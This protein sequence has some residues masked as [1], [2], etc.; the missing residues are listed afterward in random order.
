ML[1]SGIQMPK[2]VVYLST[3]A[4]LCSECVCVVFTFWEWTCPSFPLE[5]LGTFSSFQV[6]HV[7]KEE[8]WKMKVFCLNCVK[9]LTQLC[10][11]MYNTGFKSVLFV[12][13]WTEETFSHL[14][15]IKGKQLQNTKKLKA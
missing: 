11:C 12:L 5:K 2:V 9:I 14:N 7:F 4:L 15:L 3:T 8:L 13:T 6:T 10:L 1:K